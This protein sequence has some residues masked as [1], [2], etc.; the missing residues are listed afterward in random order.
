MLSSGSVSVEVFFTWEALLGLS[1]YPKTKR[2]CVCAC[3]CLSVWNW[4]R[5]LRPNVTPPHQRPG[6]RAGKRDQ[7]S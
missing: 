1:P 4:K 7:Q 5:D 3:V 2:K 6:H